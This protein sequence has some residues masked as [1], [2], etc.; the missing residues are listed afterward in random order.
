[1]EKWGNDKINFGLNY[2]TEASFDF[3]QKLVKLSYKGKEDDIFK[4]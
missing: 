3:D 2:N 1:M 4:I